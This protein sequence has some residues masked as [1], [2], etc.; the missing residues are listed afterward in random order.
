MEIEK[1]KKVDIEL[2]EICRVPPVYCKFFGHY[3]IPSNL[4]NEEE[5]EEIFEEDDEEE[6][7]LIEILPKEKKPK[8]LVK[9][10][11]TVKSRSKR[12]N[13]TSV[14]GLEQNGIDL[15]EL[16]HL[17]MKKVGIG[18]SSNFKDNQNILVIQGDITNRILEVIFENTI[19]KK[20]MIT[21]EKKQKHK[22]P[23]K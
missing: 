17:L 2:C 13:V 5:E 1:L 21:I 7:K 19:I 6:Q 16:S 14:R 8:E 4:L 11:F 18:C 15:K 23:N 10:I 22:K 3:I 9:I 20:S 12:K